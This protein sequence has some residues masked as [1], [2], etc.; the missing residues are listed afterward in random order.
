MTSNHQTMTWE[1]AVAWLRA[2]PEQQDLVKACYYDQ[3][4]QA[5]ADRFVHSEEW[6]AVC[7][8]LQP[9][10][11]GRVLDLGAGN[12][13]ASYGFACLGCAVT[14]LEPDPS[15][16][17]GAGAIAQLAHDTG[18]PIQVVQGIGEGLP[19]PDH[20]FD[21]VH[22]RQV[23]HHATDLP[24]LC[25]EVARVLRPQGVFIAT[26]EHVISR[27]ED[28]A[29]FLKS[30]P[31]HHLY[32]GE[33]A[34]LLSQYQQAFQAAGLNLQQTYGPHDSVINYFP[35]T[36]VQHQALV[37]TML[38]KLLG[39][40]LADWLLAQTPA[41]TWINRYRSW[42]DRTPGRLYSFIATKPN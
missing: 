31:L 7:Q 10:L 37:Q 40:S 19:F 12:G 15:S 39:Q 9:W 4:L 2:Q 5:A 34:F 28:L 20:S 24:Q 6:Q 14:A 25:Q 38:Q 18:V 26:R 17:V 32:G 36:Q 23:L 22:G 41:L 16:T 27:T 11:P 42:R 21:M 1:A 30:H 3:P 35:I 33:N 8:V 13:I 29:V